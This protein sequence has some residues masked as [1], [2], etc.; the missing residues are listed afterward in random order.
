[1]HPHQRKQHDHGVQHQAGP[2][3]HWPQEHLDPRYLQFKR[4]MEKEE[5]YGMQ[6]LGMIDSVVD[7]LSSALKDVTRPDHLHSQY[8]KLFAR[9][10]VL[11]N[12]C[13]T[14]ERY[15]DGYLIR[16]LHHPRPQA[17]SPARS[18]NVHAWSAAPPHS[19]R[20]DLLKTRYEESPRTQRARLAIVQSPDVKFQRTP[21]AGLIP[22]RSAGQSPYERSSPCSTRTPATPTTPCTPRQLIVESIFRQLP[23]ESTP[24]S[25]IFEPKNSPLSHNSRDR[26]VGQMMGTPRGSQWLML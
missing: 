23:R 14:L 17:W 1:M 8:K 13:S 11:K 26:G 16:E 20:V 22:G 9:F 25:R 2:Q 15:N 4:Y 7:G 10:Q 18:V 24:I 21:R 12:Y 6:R 3:R 5:N 19:P